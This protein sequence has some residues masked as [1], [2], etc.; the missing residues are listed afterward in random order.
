M[1]APVPPPRVPLFDAELSALRDDNRNL[2]ALL[3]AH[4]AFVCGGGW[5]H[6]AAGTPPKAEHPPGACWFDAAR[7]AAPAT[8]VPPSP[9]HGRR[10]SEPSSPRGP[11]TPLPGTPLPEYVDGLKASNRQLAD[12]N[13]ELVRANAELQG[14]C[15]DL[16]RESDARALFIATVSHELRTP[17]N[18]I[19]GMVSSLLHAAEQADDDPTSSP[20]SEPPFLSPAGQPLPAFARQW[21]SSTSMTGSSRARGTSGG[22]SSSSTHRR[23]SRAKPDG[24]LSAEQAESVQIIKDCADELLRTVDGVLIF[25]K[26]QAGMLAP[27]E[28]PFRAEEDVVA[29]SLRLLELR[30]WAKGVELLYG[31]SVPQG[32]VLWG[33]ADKLRTCLTN[34]VSNAVKFTERGSVRVTLEGRE[35][36]DGEETEPGVRKGAYE[37]TVRVRDTGI[38]IPGDRRGL[39][40]KSFSQVDGKFRPRYEGTGLG[41]SIVRSLVDAMGGT[42]DFDSEYGRGSEFFFTVPVGV[43]DA[44]DL[45]AETRSDPTGVELASSL[46]STSTLEAA[47]RG[48]RPSLSAETPRSPTLTPRRASSDPGDLLPEPPAKPAPPSLFPS[49]QPLDR[50]P[51]ERHSSDLSSSTLGNDAPAAWDLPSP[52]PRSPPDAHA[53]RLASSIGSRIRARAVGE[54]EAAGMLSAAQPAAT[55]VLVAE[56]NPIGA[57][58]AHKFLRR[59]GYTDVQFAL[60]GVQ[61]VDAVVRAV[62]EERRPFHIVLMDMSMPRASGIEATR[63]IAAEDLGGQQPWIVALTANALPSDRDLCLGAG[64][65]GFLPKP[66]DVEALRRAMVEFS[67]RPLPRLEG[68][69]DGMEGISGGA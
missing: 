38:G 20:P 42:I 35:T 47:P 45:D 17:L 36:G 56:D 61:A 16:K 29:P 68:R 44:P 2:A 41:L 65:H 21:S 33:D 46:G 59:L 7:P 60:D 9:A 63:M 64:M 5:R 24:S 57:K 40:F 69:E 23:D 6:S 12:R 26:S 3:H 27:A 14:R 25:S 58:V 54:P 49:L 51:Y 39:L 66:L 19:L 30:A 11:P 28:H 55:R 13:A 37:L 31:S 48:R 34:L 67:N 53:A 43:V 32:M 18:G 50:A 8:P 1:P 4:C 22:S 62:R 10:R 52:P 15:D